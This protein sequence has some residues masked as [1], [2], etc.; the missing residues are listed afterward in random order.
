[1]KGAKIK[2]SQVVLNRLCEQVLMSMKP[3]RKKADRRETENER[4]MAKQA[5]SKE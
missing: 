1:M 4:L 2:D 3:A 5:R